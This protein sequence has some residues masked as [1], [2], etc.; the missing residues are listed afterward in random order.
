LLISASDKVSGGNQIRF[1]SYPQGAARQM[2]NDLSHYDS[3]SATADGESFVSIE[4][5]TVNGIYIGAAGADANDFKEIISET[6]ELYPLVWTLEGK[7]IYRSNKDGVSN[8][9]TM[10]A[11]GGNRRQLTANAQVDA[12]GLCIPADGKYLVFGSWRNGKSNLWRVDADGGNLTQLTNGEVDVHPSCSPDTARWFI[13]EAC[14]PS[15]CCGKFQSRAAS[16]LTEFNAKWNAISNDGRRISYFF[17][18]DGKWRLGIISSDGVPPVQRLDV[19]ATLKGPATHWSPDDRLPITVC[20]LIYCAH[21]PLP[22]LTTV[23]NR[24]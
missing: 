10:D 12:R 22:R 13:R 5:N 3:L 2:P 15:R 4:T 19:P 1:L 21:S 11:D 7:I 6:G 18:A 17:M 8:L 14:K 24:C 20:R 23:P 9:W 16:L